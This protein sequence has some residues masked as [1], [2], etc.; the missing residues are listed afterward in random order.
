[1]SFPPSFFDGLADRL[2]LA[3]FDTNQEWRA[4]ECGKMIPDRCAKSRYC[5]QPGGCPYKMS[6][7]QPTTQAPQN[8]APEPPAA[9]P[10]VTTAPPPLPPLPTTKP[11][12]KTVNKFTALAARL[13]SGHESMDNEADA[14]GTEL[15]AALSKFS[16]AIGRNRARLDTV[17]EGIKAIDDAANVLSNFDPNEA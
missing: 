17:G 9:A 6:E 14:L 10:A 13:K 15:D 1:M 7:E 5:N 2:E 3:I 12:A 4:Q 16:A 11:V 8:N